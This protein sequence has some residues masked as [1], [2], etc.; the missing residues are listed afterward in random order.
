MSTPLLNAI[1]MPAALLGPI[2]A[3]GLVGSASAQT[4][5]EN[6]A[7]CNKLYSEW[8]RYNAGSSYSKQIDVEGAHEK[9]RK[10]D[11]GAGIAELTQA[12]QRQQIPVPP[13]ETARQPQ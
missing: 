12:L 9:C 5:R 7:Y 11:Y 8:S 13:V 1:R 10:G 3:I 4:S 2:V 6:M